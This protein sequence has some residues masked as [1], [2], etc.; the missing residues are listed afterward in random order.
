MQ[1]KNIDERGVEIRG[2]RAATRNRFYAEIE[3]DWGSKVVIGRVRDLSREGMFIEM[4][5]WPAIGRHFS[6][7]LNLGTPL[8]IQ[9]VVQ[10]IALCQGIGVT[11]TLADGEDSRQRLNALLRVL[12]RAGRRAEESCGFSPDELFCFASSNQ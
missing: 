1:S 4:D 12:R 10:R 7:R 11:F 6:A 2:R 5:E 9:C 3:L 8:P